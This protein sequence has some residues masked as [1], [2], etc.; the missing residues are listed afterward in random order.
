MANSVKTSKY[1]GVSVVSS[2]RGSAWDIRWNQEFPFRAYL[3][4]DGAI[5][6]NKNYKTEREAAIA[7]DF[8][9]IE[10]GMEPRNILKKK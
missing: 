7:V 9:L 8:K 1:Y 6:L 3:T 4:K 10:L 5:L 2:N